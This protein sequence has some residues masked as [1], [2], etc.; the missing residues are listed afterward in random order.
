MSSSWDH[1]SCFRRLAQKFPE[2]LVSQSP[3]HDSLALHFHQKNKGCRRAL[4]R[5]VS[6]WN[7]SSRRVEG[8][9]RGDEDSQQWGWHPRKHWIGYRPWRREFW[10][11]KRWLS[12]KREN[13]V[14]TTIS[15]ESHLLGFGHVY[16]KEKFSNSWNAMVLK[17]CSHGSIVS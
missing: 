4:G 3:M 10:A 14:A 17:V 12:F 9:G 1:F 13:H 16:M 6:L 8:K 2:G 11:L 7:A 15:L 5:F